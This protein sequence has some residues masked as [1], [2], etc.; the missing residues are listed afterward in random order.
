MTD[1]ALD[2][3]VE[4][5]LGGD[6]ITVFEIWAAADRAGITT[7]ALTEALRARNVINDTGLKYVQKMSGK[8]W[9]RVEGQGSK[10]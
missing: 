6:E 9:D 7:K 8:G 10:K 5:V 3:A 2:R 4:Q 1:K